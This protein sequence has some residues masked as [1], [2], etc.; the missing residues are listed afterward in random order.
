M[1]PAGPAARGLQALGATLLA[2]AVVA[3]TTVQTTGEGAIGLNRKQRMS[4]LVSEAQLE[5]SAKVAY[6]EVMQAPSRNMHSTS[7]RP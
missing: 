5:E 1:W 2:G 7:I 4:P 3:C 6:A